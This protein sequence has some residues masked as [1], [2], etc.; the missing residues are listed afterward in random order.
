M[1]RITAF[2]LAFTIG[3]STDSFAAE[4]GEQATVGWF[5]QQIAVARQVPAAS[6]KDAQRALSD[7][8]ANV[9]GLGLSK[10]LTEA[11]AVLVGRALGVNVTTRSPDATL[12][13]TRAKALA[14]S[15]G[16]LSGP[17]EPVTTHDAG[18]NPNDSSDNGK[19]KK[20]G[21]NK[22]ESEPCAPSGN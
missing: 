2:T 1:L 22:S 6:E 21:H 11:D 17:D 20:K 9:S 5:L 14:V 8:G 10:P 12:D 15:F 19:G 18:G 3:T 16:A 7:P 4:N 13:Q